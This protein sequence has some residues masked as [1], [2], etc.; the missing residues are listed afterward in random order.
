MM[1]ASPLLVGGSLLGLGMWILSKCRGPLYQG[2]FNSSHIHFQA[3][4]SSQPSVMRKQG[5]VDFLQ[6]GAHCS[7]LTLIR[8]S[9]VLNSSLTCRCSSEGFVPGIILDLQLGQE[10]R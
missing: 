3:N 10:W 5:R 1:M 2:G 9:L 7:Y 6:V 8:V 4:S